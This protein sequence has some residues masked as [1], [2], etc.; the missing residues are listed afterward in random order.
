MDYSQAIEYVLSFT[1]WERAPAQ[2][3]AAANFD[4]RRVQSL[5]ARLG[6]PHLGR[7]TIHIAGSKGKGSVAAMIGSIL[8]AAGYRSGLYTSPHLNIRERI[9]VDGQPIGEDEFAHLA[10]ASPPR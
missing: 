8:R 6:N 10:E 5:L 4:L 1:D 7:Q 2:A 9:V 3:F